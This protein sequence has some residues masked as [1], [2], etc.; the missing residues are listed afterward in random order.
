[1]HA[2]PAVLSFGHGRPAVAVLLTSTIDYGPALAQDMAGCGAIG[3]DAGRLRC[4][5]A[6]AGR[7]PSSQ[8]LT[9][10]RRS[11]AATRVE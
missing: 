9:K 5:D 7:C 1:M 6:L 8:C 11:K 3:D 4:C 10:P 2:C